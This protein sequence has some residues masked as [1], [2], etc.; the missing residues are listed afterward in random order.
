MKR[1]IIILIVLVAVVAAVVWWVASGQ[2]GDTLAGQPAI[3]NLVSDLGIGGIAAGLET[4]EAASI[5]EQAVIRGSGTIE[6]EELVITSEMGG[7]IVSVL[8]GEGDEVAAEQP[9]IELDASDIIA[10]KVQVESLVATARANLAEARSGPR[11]EHVAAA[12]AE[13][14]RA[15]VVAEAAEE[16]CEQAKKLVAHPQEIQVELQVIRGELA[17]A[18]KGLE[19]AGTQLKEA[20]IQRDE[21]NRNQNGDAAMTEQQI[22]QKQ[23]E[24]AEIDVQTA[25][26]Y[27]DGLAA[28]IESLEAMRDY[29]VHLIVNANQ[30]C[31]A[32]NLALAGIDVAEAHLALAQAGPRPEDVAVA[33]AQWREA[34]AALKRIDATLDKLILKAPH[35]GVVKERPANVGELAA[36]GAVL[37]TLADL[38]E[39]NLRVFIPETQIGRVGEGQAARVNVDAYPGHVFEG[40][41]AYISPRAEFTPKN[42]QTQEERVNLVFAVKIRLD[43]PDHRLKPGMP[44]DA[45][46]LSGL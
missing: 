17:A 23:V 41:V 9:L 2:G 12:E 14:D 1:I 30:A 7:R 8:V 5:S 18:E 32:G 21:A 13:L 29:P 16:T 37:M 25:E 4:T 36:P 38:D 22:A 24:A 42:V 19:L 20:Q 43:N 10:Q 11:D 26:G 46:I 3:S 31:S 33:E 35:D 27:R 15:T 39:V 28:Q 45:E 44:A 40:R 6:A 34:E